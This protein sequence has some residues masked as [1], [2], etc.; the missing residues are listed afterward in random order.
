MTQARHS[1]FREFV[2]HPVFGW[3]LRHR[4]G[5]IAAVV[6]MVFL[7]GM[8]VMGLAVVQCPSQLVTEVP[9]PGCGMTRSVKALVTGDPTGVWHS[10]LF[11][12]FLVFIGFLFLLGA[13]LPG[14]L[15]LELSEKVERFERRTALCGVG[16]GLLLVYW[17]L[18]LMGFLG[19]MASVYP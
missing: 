16:L 19:G 13:L 6:V 3:L 11:G 4:G 9:C 8:N 12:P 18:R 15:R 2:T 10:H 17:V 5:C 7:A 1:G 14:K